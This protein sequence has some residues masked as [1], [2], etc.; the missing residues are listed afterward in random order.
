MY[1][2]KK[3]KKKIKAL[4]KSKRDI[5]NELNGIAIDY[6]QEYRLRTGIDKQ[7]DE[8]G[9][10]MKMHNASKEIDDKFRTFSK[11]ALLYAIEVIKDE[12]KLKQLKSMYKYRY[13]S[14]ANWLNPEK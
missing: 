4:E 13:E 7:Y 2:S 5:I 1:L 9:D 8:D 12:A 10:Y 6:R 14:K 3:I 11:R